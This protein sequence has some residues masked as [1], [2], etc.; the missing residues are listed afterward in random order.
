MIL[1]ASR[2]SNVPVYMAARYMALSSTARASSRSI[3]P[4]A[5]N[6]SINAVTIAPPAIPIPTA[7]AAVVASVMAVLL[8]SD[9][10]YLSSGRASV[11][12]I[13]LEQ[14][15]VQTVK[16]FVAAA[17]AL[18][19]YRAFGGDDAVEERIGDSH[20]GHH[21]ILHPGSGRRC[22][23]YGIGNLAD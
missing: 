12:L 17:V 14:E 13:E 19:R 9:L 10:S 6:R 5:T 1:V 15:W 18:K 21:G 3:R 11:R 8:S 7:F 22:H 16:Q 4:L 23:Q 20:R 2:P